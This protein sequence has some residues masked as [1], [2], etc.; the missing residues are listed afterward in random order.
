[1]K[2]WMIDVVERQ[3]SGPFSPVRS[4]HQ[5]LDCN[6]SIERQEVSLLGLRILCSQNKTWPGRT[7]EMKA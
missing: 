6:P 1:M 4:L 2:M 7:L 5:Q 3:S